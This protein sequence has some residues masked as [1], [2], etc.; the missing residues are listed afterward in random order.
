VRDGAGLDL[1]RRTLAAWQSALPAPTD[2]AGHE[3][4]NLIQVGRLV[5]E[6]AALRDESRGAH[7]RTDYPNTCEEW[8]RHLV[9]SR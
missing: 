5:A 9:F 1:A 2:R 6:A 7:Y 3:L 4:A 8:R